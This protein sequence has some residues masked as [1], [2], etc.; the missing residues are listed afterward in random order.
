MM[1][2]SC[3]D[4]SVLPLRAFV[5]GV[6]VNNE[7]VPFCDATR[8]YVRLNRFSLRDFN[9]ALHLYHLIDRARTV[10]G[11]NL[12]TRANCSDH[13]PYKSGEMQPYI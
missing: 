7:I 5:L 2:W 12:E 8:S 13:H 6:L 10:S 3:R 4:R 9:I 1:N 11:L